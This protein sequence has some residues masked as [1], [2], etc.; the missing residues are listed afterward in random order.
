MDPRGRADRGP[1]QGAAIQAIPGKAEEG[2]SLVWLA[3]D[4][5]AA[6]GSLGAASPAALSAPSLSDPET[7]RSLYRAIQPGLLRYLRVLAGP[8]AEDVAAEAWLHVA[9][10]LRTF[11]GDDDGF[12]GWV[13]TIARHRAVD[14]ARRRGRRPALVSVSDLPDMAGADDTS[15]AAIEAVGTDTALR[16]IAT[17]PPDQAEAVL[18]RAVVGLDAATAGKVVGKRAGAVRSAAHRGLRTLARRLSEAQLAVPG[19]EDE[20]DGVT[21]PRSLALKDMR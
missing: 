19:Q 10:D 1:D 13:T 21:Q 20:D 6:R 8:D 5:N 14:L 4:D 16:L 7:F 17:L 12:R 3:T 15:D 18:L 2:A 9:R 11:T